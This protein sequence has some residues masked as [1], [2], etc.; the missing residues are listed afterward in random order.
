MT[1]HDRLM[2]ALAEIKEICSK[3]EDAELGCGKKC[4]F[5]LGKDGDDFRGCE[6]M[7]YTRQSTDAVIDTPMEWGED[8][9]S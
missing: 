8:G 1:K 3:Q 2:N 7:N 6:V 4:P 9:E 5:L